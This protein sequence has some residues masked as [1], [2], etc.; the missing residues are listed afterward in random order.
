MRLDIVQYSYGGRMRSLED[1]RDLIHAHLISAGIESTIYRH[2]W[3]DKGVPL[4]MG[5]D[6]SQDKQITKPR[7]V[8][9]SEVI[10]DDRL[11]GRQCER[12]EA[13]DWWREQA[14]IWTPFESNYWQLAAEGIQSI[15]AP[16]EYHPVW[17]RYE[18]QAKKPVDFFFVGAMS[19]RRALILGQLERYGKHVE[20][21]GNGMWGK[22]RDRIAAMS[23]VLPYPL[24]YDYDMFNPMRCGYLLSNGSLSVIE[25]SEMYRKMWPGCPVPSARYEDLVDLLMTTVELSDDERDA[26]AAAAAKWW[27]NRVTVSIEKAVKGA[28]DMLGT[29][30]ADWGF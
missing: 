8:V 24:F 1:Y 23:K 5:W 28:L 22:H 6:R 3:P 21:S 10:G 15:H 19:P 9:I 18:Q 30:Y 26:Q 7:I 17:E 29:R 2:G 25:D 20:N 16:I 27:R 13:M 11:F 4:F 12:A 14:A